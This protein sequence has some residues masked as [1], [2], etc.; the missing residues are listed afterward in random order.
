MNVLEIKKICKKY[1]KELLNNFNLIVKKQ[2]IVA[3]CGKSGSGKSTLLNII[4]LLEKADSGEIIYFGKKKVNPFTREASELL[5]NKIGYLF[6]NF[7]LVENETVFYNLMIALAHVK[8]KNKRKLVSNALKMVGL[9]GFEN[10]VIHQCSGGEQ[11]RIAVARLLLKPCELILADEP[12]GSLDDG[13]KEVIWELIML[14]KQQCKTI[15]IVTHDTFISQK[16]DR[17]IN[18][19]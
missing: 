1:D 5:R 18:I 10:K 13:N 4:G 15:I 6:Q 7:A 12:T 17:S 14:L 11:Q 16:C 8:V 2:E 9:E 19:G 3:I